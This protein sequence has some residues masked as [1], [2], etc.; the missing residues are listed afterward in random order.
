M[1]NNVKVVVISQ[2]RPLLEVITITKQ[3]NIEKMQRE[4]RATLPDQ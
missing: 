2:N 3:R 4:P 1:M